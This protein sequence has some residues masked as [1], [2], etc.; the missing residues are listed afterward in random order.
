MTTFV[1]A[2]TVILSVLMLLSNLM[3]QVVNSYGTNDI[4]E[5][6]EYRVI[7]NEF[8]SS[9]NEIV[10]SQ[11]P[12]EE[13]DQEEKEATGILTRTKEWIFGRVQAAEDYWE[14][15]II[16]RAWATL[17]LF[18]KMIKLSL[19]TINI[20]FNNMSDIISVPKELILMLIT[21]TGLAITFLIVKAIWEKKI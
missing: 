15:S 5:F 20:T 13:A 12:T 9:A 11:N 17:K 7:Y 1:F 14:G 18:P 6:E 19:R 4:P 16:R 3:V 10:Q 21:L 2:F 8:N